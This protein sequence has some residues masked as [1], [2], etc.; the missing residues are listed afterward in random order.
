M[1]LGKIIAEA[2]L[3]D[4]EYIS[5]FPSYGA[6]MRGG[7][8]HCFVRVAD[9]PLSSPFTDFFDIAI[10]FNRPSW[11]KFKSSFNKNTL[12]VLN[13]DFVSPGLKESYFKNCHTFC[14]NRTAL[15]CGN[16][17]VANI[18]ALGAVLRLAGNFLKKEKVIKVLKNNFSNGPKL[19]QN[20]TAL[21][22]GE[23]LCS[24]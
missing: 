7:T 3:G 18:V 12:I 22:Y 4:Y 17:K 24:E 13:G 20:L 8:A 5:A 6:E 15:S 9:E 10:I 19:K 1:R 2:V 16:I 23:R 11:D 14:L 21:N